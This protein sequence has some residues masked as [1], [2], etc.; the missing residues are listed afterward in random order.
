MPIATG[1]HPSGSLYRRLPIR[2]ASKRADVGVTTAGSA[3]RRHS[4]N[5]GAGLLVQLAYQAGSET[6]GF[7]N[8]GSSGLDANAF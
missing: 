2:Q 5:A 3:L 1:R 7:P 4:G 8:M 6:K